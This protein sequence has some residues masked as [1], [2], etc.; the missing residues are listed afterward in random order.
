MTLEKLRFHLALLEEVTIL[1]SSVF[2]AFL[3]GAG[4]LK[5]MGVDYISALLKAGLCWLILT[6][7]VAVIILVSIQVIE[8]KNKKAVIHSRAY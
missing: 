1:F 7:I 2:L 4:L 6:L 3:I 5:G 8:W